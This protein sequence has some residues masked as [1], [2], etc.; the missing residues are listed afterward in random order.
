[1]IIIGILLFIGGAI[2]ELIFLYSGYQTTIPDPVWSSDVNG[3]QITDNITLEKNM[4][5][6]IF[7]PNND[8]HEGNIIICDSNNSIVLFSNMSDTINESKVFLWYYEVSH[9]SVQNANNYT[10]SSNATGKVTIVL[11]S[12]IEVDE[13]DLS[14]VYGICG[15]L[16]ISIIGIVMFLV[17]IIKLMRS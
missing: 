6:V 13:N 2:G 11:S 7:N 4:Y 5:H 10:I 16:I 15:F 12:D 3:N 9:F 8:T 14:M 1:M 17:G